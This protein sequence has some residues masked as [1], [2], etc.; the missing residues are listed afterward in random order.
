LK[1]IFCFLRILGVD[2]NYLF[3]L[4]LFQILSASHFNDKTAW[5]ENSDWLRNFG[6]S[7]VITTDAVEFRS[8]F[9]V[10]LNNDDLTWSSS[11]NVG[12]LFNTDAE[13]AWPCISSDNVIAFAITPPDGNAEIF[14][15]NADGSGKT[16][17]TNQSG[18]LYGP[19]YSADAKK[20]AFYN[21][22]NH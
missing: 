10:N 22:F 13:D 19:A 4:F 9:S 3:L 12:E 14:L 20:I 15:I 6:P 2:V 5:Y 21:H 16:Q 18:R 17:L 7:Q 1:G 11:K 8:V